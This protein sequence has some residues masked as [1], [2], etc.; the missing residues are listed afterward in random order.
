RNYEMPSQSG[1]ESA[2]VLL[3]LMSLPNPGKEITTAIHSAAAWFAKTPLHDVEFKAAAGEGREL[4]PTPGAAPLWA[5]Y[6]EI[7]TDRPIFGDR[8]KTIH[9]DVRELSKERRNG[10]SWFSPRPQR[11]LDEYARWRITHP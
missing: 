8:D 1:G 5:R 9:D 10:Y 6:Y 7:G 3:F 2:K 11:A 4:V